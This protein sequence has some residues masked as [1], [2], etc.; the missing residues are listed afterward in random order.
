MELQGGQIG[1]HSEFGKGSTFAFYVETAR[2][3]APVES[4]AAQPAQTLNRGLSRVVDGPI[5][6]ATHAPDLHV[7][8]EYNCPSR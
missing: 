5:A 6:R 3:E 4:P 1:V 8:G 2:I 7:L